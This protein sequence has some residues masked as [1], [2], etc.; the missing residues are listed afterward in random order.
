MYNDKC[1][2]LDFNRRVGIKVKASVGI[3]SSDLVDDGVSGETAD[4]EP[5]SVF[6]YTV[7][8]LLTEKITLK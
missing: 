5:V 6:R 8:A 1:I 2:K 3:C 7:R 4:I